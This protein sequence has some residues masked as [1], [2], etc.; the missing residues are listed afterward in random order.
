MWWWSTTRN[1]DDDDVHDVND[2]NLVDDIDVALRKHRRVS[3]Y[4]PFSVPLYCLCA[5]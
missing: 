1:N 5:G 3:M 2:V 4:L